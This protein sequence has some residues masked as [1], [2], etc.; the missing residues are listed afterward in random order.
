[1]QHKPI[2]A[3]QFSMPLCDT[4]KINFSHKFLRL[5]STPYM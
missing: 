3:K 2:K 5:N 4:R 1:M